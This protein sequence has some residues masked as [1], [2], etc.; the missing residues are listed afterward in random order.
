ML[1]KVYLVL[2]SVACLGLDYLSGPD[3][4]FPF[5]Y[6]AP[7]S[8]AAWYEGR[9]WG[10][11]LAVVLS[12]MRFSLRLVWDSPPTIGAAVANAGIRI[13]VFSAFAWLTACLAEQMRQLRHTRQMEAILG[14]CSVCG[15]IHDHDANAWQPLDQYLSGRKQRFEREVC[16][17][18]QQDLGETYDRR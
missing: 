11:A 12:L 15:R 3:I 1:R 6:L 8:L 9:A 10:L 13:T 16:P 18:C 17:A 7:V 2:L 5:F 4:Q 14:V